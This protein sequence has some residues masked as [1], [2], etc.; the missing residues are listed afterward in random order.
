LPHVILLHESARHSE[1]RFGFGFG[2]GGMVRAV[3]T[4]PNA[5]DNLAFECGNVGSLDGVL[6]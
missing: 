2:R 3:Q 6:C 1:G 5:N 4:F